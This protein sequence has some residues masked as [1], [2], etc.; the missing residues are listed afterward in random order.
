MLLGANYVF[1]AVS[2]NYSGVGA[3]SLPLDSH[4]ENFRNYCSMDLFRGEKRLLEALA[5]E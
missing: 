1:L 3:I 2:F 4:I 5:G